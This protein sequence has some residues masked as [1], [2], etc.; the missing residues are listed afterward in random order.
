MPVLVQL[1]QQHSTLALQQANHLAVT[2]AI[3]RSPAAAV[4]GQQPHA[5]EMQ[6]PQAKVQQTAA[7]QITCAPAVTSM[8][9]AGLRLASGAVQPSKSGSIM[10]DIDVHEELIDTKPHFEPDEEEY[11]A[12]FVSLTGLADALRHTPA[13]HQ[14]HMRV[15]W[16]FQ[17]VS[18]CNS[19]HEAGSHCHHVLMES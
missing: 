14:M 17:P 3:G 11:A 18:I 19:V 1:L 9:A 5:E 7:D 2:A 12:V 13:R 8:S 15:A 4:S 16:W 10:E 6:S